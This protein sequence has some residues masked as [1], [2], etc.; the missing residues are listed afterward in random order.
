MSTIRVL[1]FVCLA[2]MQTT[3]NPLCQKN[4]DNGFPEI[5]VS[6]G[7]QKVEVNFVESK[8]GTQKFI[9]REDDFRL[10]NEN[11]QTPLMRAVSNGDLATVE[12]L[13]EAGAL[14]DSDE[15][16]GYR[17]LEIAAVRN[18]RRQSPFSGFWFPEVPMP[19]SG[20]K[21]RTSST[22]LVETAVYHR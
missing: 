4:S 14:L 18:R 17:L 7:R 9:A 15:H 2:A 16:Y 5:K 10:A 6:H 20:T 1:L 13:L 8:E 3:A 19:S 22:R 21:T 11:E 12:S